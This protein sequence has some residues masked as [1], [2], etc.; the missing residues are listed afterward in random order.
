MLRDTTLLADKD[1]QYTRRETTPAEVTAAVCAVHRAAVDDTDE[2][3]LL[4][5][6]GLAPWPTIQPEPKEPKRSPGVLPEHG[7][8]QRYQREIFTGVQPCRACCAAHAERFRDWYAAN[9]EHARRLSRERGRRRR[10][11]ER[12]EQRHLQAVPDLNEEKK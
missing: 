1:P 10:E 5:M 7:T 2:L 4:R 6:L 11:R 12:D 3:E 9:L 8:E